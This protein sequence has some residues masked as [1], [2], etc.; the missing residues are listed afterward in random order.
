VEDP[1]VAA[2]VR[3]GPA[4]AIAVLLLAL[5][6]LLAGPAAP[7]ARAAAVGASVPLE[8][9]L[10]GPSTVAA[11]SND[12]YFVNGTGTGEAAG[13][14]LTWNASLSGANTSG[15]SVEPVSGGVTPGT[16]TKIY[17]N[18]GSTLQTLTITVELKT[19]AVANVTLNLTKTV[20]VVAPVVLKAVLVAGP[21][22]G[23]LPFTLAVY[24]DGAKVGSVSIPSLAADGTYN[25]TFDYP[26]TSLSPG[27]HTFLL[28]LANEHGLVTF[29]GGGTVLTRT[30]YVAPPPTD[31][32]LW[33]VV[34]VVAFF[35]VL[36][37]LASRVAARRRGGTRR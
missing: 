37:I 2:A 10:T 35:G 15:A 31:T 8:G 7:G 17:L 3:R 1:E 4:A 30:F 24:L 12:T 27:T 5:G 13:S 23:V 22:A 16:P 36:L 11:G 21:N 33:I 20:N 25:L 18:P 9:N 26:A 32:A 6:L 29:A 28:S 34:G 19:S 14:T